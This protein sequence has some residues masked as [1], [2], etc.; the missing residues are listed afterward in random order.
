MNSDFHN[1]SSSSGLEMKIWTW[2]C[3]VLRIVCFSSRLS[4]MVLTA[5]IKYWNISAGRAS[6]SMSSTVITALSW[7][8]LSA[9]LPSTPV[10]RWLP[11][12]GQIQNLL[13]VFPACV[14]QIFVV[15]CVDCNGVVCVGGVYSGCFTT[16]WKRMKWAPRFWW[17][18]IRWTCLERSPSCLSANWT[19]GTPH[20]LRLT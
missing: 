9:S 19:S 13:L 11:A 16:L 10:W 20:T 5:L 15:E 8:T 14:T 3:N 12:P 2:T 18:L 1:F 6:T 17:S 4:W 7:I